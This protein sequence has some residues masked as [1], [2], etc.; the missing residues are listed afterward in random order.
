MNPDVRR[1]RVLFER[2]W[3]GAS[4]AYALLRI[5]VAQ[6]FLVGYGL[7]IAVFA[8]IE[9]CSTPVYAL[10]ASQ[11]LQAMI[12]RR[13]STAVR[14]LMLAIAGFVAPDAYVVIAARRIPKTLYLA[15]LAWIVLGAAL[16][17][18]RLRRQMAALRAAAPAGS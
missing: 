5:G 15:V 2:T 14:S 1:R 4:L 17:V 11:A 18:R 16:G 10:G 7:N 12:D 9:L 13:R 8:T 3:L 6:Q